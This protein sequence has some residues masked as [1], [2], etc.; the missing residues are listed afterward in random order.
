MYEKENEVHRKKIEM[1]KR[2][3]KKLQEQQSKEKE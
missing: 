2:D 1:A 3:L